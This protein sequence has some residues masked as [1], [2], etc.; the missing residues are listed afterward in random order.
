MVALFRDT[1]DAA[2]I[3]NNTNDVILNRSCRGMKE[4]AF[5]VKGL[6]KIEP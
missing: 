5:Y 3:V 2:H 4:R 1:M 6:H